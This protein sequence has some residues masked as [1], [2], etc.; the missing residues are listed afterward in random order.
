[1]C[2]IGTYPTRGNSRG[3]QSGRR[4][5]GV[6]FYAQ[7]TW[8]YHEGQDIR[9]VCMTNQESA[10]LLLNGKEIAAPKAKDQTSGMIWWD[11]PFQS[12][13]LK[14]E[15]LDSKGHAVASY[16]IET[17]GR[18]AALKL[19]TDKTLLTGRGRIAHVIIE[20]KDQEGRTVS[21][22]DNEISVRVSGAGRLLG[23]EGGDMSDI[24]N[25]RDWRQRVVRGRLLAYIEATQD[26]GTI[27]V[28]AGSP[29][30]D[31]GEMTITVKGQGR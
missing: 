11:I 9:V 5:P 1:M 24:S 18:P 3:R 17:T 16:E 8:N 29:L 27:T 31:E 26:E 14:A 20:V 10:R 12:G 25:L 23:L 4:D 7:D 13:V 28:S 6:S 15:A 21:L 2:Y 19:T 22:S 30:L